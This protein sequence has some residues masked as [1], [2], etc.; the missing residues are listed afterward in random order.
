MAANLTL[1]NRKCAGQ[2]LL[3]SVL[4]EA[5]MVTHT[6]V[7]LLA[8]DCELPCFDAGI[9]KKD[10]PRHQLDESTRSAYSG[11]GLPATGGSTN[12][13][14]GRLTLTHGVC[15]GGQVVL[16]PRPSILF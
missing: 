6:A 13:R 3:K 11:S 12:A 7:L 1:L 4:I 14:W 5:G 16:I 8:A 2:K 15:L 9:M 10:A